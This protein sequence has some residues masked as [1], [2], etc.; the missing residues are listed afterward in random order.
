M[1]VLVVVTLGDGVLIVLML[2]SEGKTVY[3]N[4]PWVVE[5]LV[6]VGA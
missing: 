2:L 3:E 5:V 4:R 6:R 1:F